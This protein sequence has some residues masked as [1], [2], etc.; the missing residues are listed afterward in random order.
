MAKSDDL[1]LT[2]N[3]AALSGWTSVRV[4]RSI[5]KVPAD[6]EIAMTDRFP[7][8]QSLVVC[9]PGDRCQVMLGGDLVVT[10][11]VNRFVAS[12]DPQSHGI[13]VSGRSLSQDVVDCS[14][15]WPSGQISGANALQIAQKLSAPY[16]VA[17][18][19]T[20]DPGAVIPQF[21]L[22][23]G[24]SAFDIIERVCRYS[25]LLVYD[26]PDGTLVLAQVGSTKAASGVKE[27]V[28]A[29]RASFEWRDD[30]QYGSYSVFGLSVNTFTDAGVLNQPLGTATDPNVKRHR[31][32]Y[33]VAEAGAAGHEVSLK[34]AKWEAARRLGRAWRLRAR[35][36]SWRDSAGK[37]WTPNSLVSVQFPSIRLASAE[38]CLGEVSYIR[39]ENGTGAELMLMPK[40]AFAPQPINLLPILRDAVPPALVGR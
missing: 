24:E 14:A 18:T 3:G 12:I 37:L 8:G 23:I 11:Y 30:E 21:N 27:G 4:T 5:E 40:D 26:K 31:L 17:V 6:F 19:A 7:A 1:T 28:N 15:E 9:Q 13:S 34:R 2:V 36:D 32:R 39:D 22:N 20:A 38:L 29:T 25:G 10:G 35:V 33:F 16:G